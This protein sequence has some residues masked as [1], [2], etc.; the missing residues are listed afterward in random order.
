MTKELRNHRLRKMRWLASKRTK[1]ERVLIQLIKKDLKLNAKTFTDVPRWRMSSKRTRVLN[2][3]STTQALLAPNLL[4]L[5]TLSSFSTSFWM[6]LSSLNLNS[7]KSSLLQQKQSEPPRESK[8]EK[9]LNVKSKSRPKLYSK[10]V[11]RRKTIKRLS[12]SASLQ[13]GRFMHQL[14]KRLKSRRSNLLRSKK[15]H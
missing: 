11:N 8:L 13:C 10:S 4:W 1:M 14:L 2:K 6:S 12:R 3:R 15:T 7:H 9:K 5:K